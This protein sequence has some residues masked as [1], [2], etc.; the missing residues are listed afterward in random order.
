MIYSKPFPINGADH[1]A[2]KHEAEHLLIWAELVDPGFCEKHGIELQ[3][4][5]LMEH[6]GRTFPNVPTFYIVTG[7]PQLRRIIGEA[8]EGMHPAAKLNFLQKQAQHAV[9]YLDQCIEAVRQSGFD[10]PSWEGSGD[11]DKLID[12]V[13]NLQVEED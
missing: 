1:I 9:D 5:S 12:C 4:G 11:T 2:S 3:E 13:K 6:E 8:W 10:V 7:L